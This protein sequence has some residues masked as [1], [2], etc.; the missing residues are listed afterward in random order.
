MLDHVQGPG[1]GAFTQIDK[2]IPFFSPDG[3]SVGFFVGV[4]LRRQTLSGETF[5]VVCAI[6]Q[7]VARRE[8][9]RGQSNRLRH[10]RSG[11]WALERPGGW[12]NARSADDGR[13]VGRRARSPVPGCAAGRHARSCSRWPSPAEGRTQ[14]AVLDLRTEAIS[15]RHRQRRPGHYSTRR[16]PRVSGRSERCGP[17]VF[18]GQCLAGH[19]RTGRRSRRTDS[20]VRDRR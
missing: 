10:E 17:C 11:R 2:L 5:S 19:R 8:L 9:G 6:A 16:T 1:W 15:R 3:Q 7:R 14:I 13:P 18:D 4:E 20:G 12:R